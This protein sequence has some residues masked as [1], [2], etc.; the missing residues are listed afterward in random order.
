MIKK[1]KKR[2]DI[3]FISL[4]YTWFVMPVTYD[5]HL[6]VFLFF[7]F[8]FFSFIII[9][10]FFILRT[11]QVFLFVPINTNVK[12]DKYKVRI[13]MDRITFNNVILKNT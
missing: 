8:Y 11:I 6:P 5:L 7:I 4:F 9:F 13:H 1:K 10:L 3:Y 2:H 12:C